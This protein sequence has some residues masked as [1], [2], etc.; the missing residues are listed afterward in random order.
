MAKY[1]GTDGIRGEAN[2][3][4]MSPNMLLKIAQSFGIILKK[5]S[6]RPKVLIGKDTRVSGYMIEGVIAS[7]LCSVGVDVLFVGPLPTPGIAYLTRGMRANAGIMI[8]ASHNP[9][10]D[11]GIKLFDHNGFKLPDHD[12]SQIEQLIDSPDLDKYLVN[13]EQLGRAKRIDDAIGQYAV[14]LKERFPKN[15]K[16]DGKKIVLDCAH[17]AGYKVTPKVFEEL[18][19]KVISIHD[20]PNGF[21][22]NYECGALHPQNLAE[23]VVEY[24][25]DIGFALDGD[26]DRLIVVDEKGNILDG[27]HII[28]MCALEMKSQNQL[29]NNGVCVTIM[30]N[31]GFDVAMENAGIHV[32]RT[33]V[34]DRNVM[35]SMLTNDFILGGEQSGHLIFLDSSTTG[36]ATIACLKVLEMMCHTNKKI[37]ELTSIMKKF[38]QIT[39]NVKVKSKPP[40]ANLHK[41]NTLIKRFEEELGSTGR[42]L[43][44]YSGTE[45]LA[46]ITLEGPEYKR[47]EEMAKQIENELLQEIG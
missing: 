26:A 42:V 14:F 18:G 38:P 20:D 10:Q 8:S 40:L 9:F 46:R 12:E 39:K 7:G 22:I 24:K 37:S 6:E 19:A 34:G 3:G 41:T 23:K 44:R 29:K 33:S 28:A 11:N 16:L 31:K 27:D 47:I 30:S 21:N 13:S 5:R 45:S 15:L 1:F 4:L 35:E 36:D 2:K 17:G 32:I 43:L 25:A